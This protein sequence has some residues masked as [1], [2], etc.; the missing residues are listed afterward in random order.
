M[1]QNTSTANS[2]SSLIQTTSNEMIFPIDPEPF[3]FRLALV[4]T[5]AISVIGG[6]FLVSTIFSSTGLNILSCLGGIVIGALSLQ[7]VERFL[8]Q[9]WT[10]NRFVQLTDEAITLLTNSTTP[11]V[12][13]N[14]SQQIN[15]H[16]WYFEI[17][18]RSR[19]PKGWYVVAIALEQDDL[20]LPIYAL[21]PAEDYRE[22][23][24]N[25]TKYKIK[26]SM[27]ALEDHDL[28]LAGQQRRLRIAE[29]A[30]GVD[31]SEMLKADFDQFITQLETLYPGW[32]P[33]VRS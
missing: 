20:Y 12:T 29:T 3:G 21:M 15:V 16:T 32:M 13:L 14:P 28:R 2:D 7:V 31:G 9:I 11:Q 17:N 18:K 6:Y 5:L 19:A 25:F 22:A 33:K 23:R 1:M 8:K 4:I 27:G 10:S 30:R 24:F 26:S